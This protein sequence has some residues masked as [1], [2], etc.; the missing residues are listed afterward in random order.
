MEDKQNDPNNNLDQILHCTVRLFIFV[1]LL[2]LTTFYMLK[3][4]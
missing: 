1:Y 3:Y 4:K 2:P